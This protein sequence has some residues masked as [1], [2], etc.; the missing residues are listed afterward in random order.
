MPPRDLA[1]KN[2]G[3][4]RPWMLPSLA[5]PV[6]ASVFATFCLFDSPLRRGLCSSS[7][8]A[9]VCSGSI[10]GAALAPGAPLPRELA[11][12]AGG[13]RR[14]WG[15]WPQSCSQ[16]GGVRSEHQS[17]SWSAALPCIEK[18]LG[19]LDLAIRSGSLDWPATGLAAP[20]WLP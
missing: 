11:Y 13:S 19:R 18:S 7:L 20:G 3:R 15:E 4:P 16:V 5:H 10:A 2:S 8:S 9:G 6:A 12:A 17:S 1:E 14:A